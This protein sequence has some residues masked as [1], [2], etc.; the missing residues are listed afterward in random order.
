MQN[1]YFKLL[2]ILLIIAFIFPQITLAAWY[3]PFSWHIWGDFWNYLFHKQ[4]PTTACTKEAKVCPD[5][6]TVGR[7]GP[8]CEFVPCP[9][10]K[11]VL[12]DS[13]KNVA[14][15]YPNPYDISK[16]DTIDL[17]KGHALIYDAGN[18]KPRAYDVAVTAVGD[19]DSDGVPDGAI[20]VYQGWGAN[21]I[22]PIIFVFSNKN[23]ALTQIN[24][25]V[26]DMS[27]WQDETQ[28]KSLSIDNGILTVNI[29]ILSEAD[30]QLPHY[31]Q[32][33]SV[34]KT[35][36]Y[37]LINGELVEQQTQSLIK[38]YAKQIFANANEANITFVIPVKASDL[39]LTNIKYCILGVSVGDLE[40]NPDNTCQN[41]NSNQFIFSYSY[42][43]TNQILNIK[44]TNL[45]DQ[46]KKID[47]GPF[48]IQCASCMEGLNLSGIHDMNG[49]LLPNMTVFVHKD[50]NK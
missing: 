45:T 46:D 39:N 1:K 47:Y 12:I 29:L 15:V 38:N 25:A 32:Q 42:N 7:V 16:N 50:Y 3:N 14:L 21:R 41:D 37:K 43:G 9:V 11:G 35:V 19:L 30:K 5:G 13:L 27:N 26:P 10:P 17:V 18:I 34:P 31:Q 20:G 23:G 49:N 24:S 44:A 6:S 48:N 4:T 33:A 8:K 36:H 22:T 40:R 28:I 2:L